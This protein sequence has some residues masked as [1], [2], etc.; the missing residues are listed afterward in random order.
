MVC[1]VGLESGVRERPIYVCSSLL[2][3]LRSF[4]EE[5]ADPDRMSPRCYLS[6][7]LFIFQLT[8][9]VMIPEKLMR[10]RLARS[11]P[12]PRWFGLSSIANNSP[13]F[14]SQTFVSVITA[15]LDHVQ[16][17]LWMSSFQGDRGC[18]VQQSTR[19]IKRCLLSEAAFHR[20]ADETLDQV[21]EKLEELIE[22]NIMDDEKVPEISY[23]SGVLTIIFPPHGSWV[24]NKQTPNK[25]LWWSSPISGPRR[26]EYDDS[27]K[28]WVYSRAYDGNLG[29]EAGSDRSNTLGGALVEE[30]RS[31][32]GLELH[33]DV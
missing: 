29:T 15:S 1:R 21:Q 5:T 25:Q 23:A 19:V 7:F 17:S 2:V 9:F 28:K 10:L 31:L 13:I 27:S 30:I 8:S 14:S 20:I 16:R 4:F 12:R 24:I 33:L 6:R 22:N 11:C 3:V 32:Y 26:Y 18:N